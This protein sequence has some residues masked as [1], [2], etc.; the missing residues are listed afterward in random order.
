MTP[1]PAPMR[2]GIIGAGFMGRTYSEVI[3]KNLTDEAR[4]VAVSGGKRAPELARDYGADHV[5]LWEALCSRDDIDAIIVSSPHEHHAEQCIAAAKAGKHVMVEK[6]MAASVEGCDEILNTARE[7]GMH[8]GVAFTQR[9]RMNPMK[10]KEIIDSGELGRVLHIQGWHVVPEGTTS[11]PAWQNSRGNVGVL[12]GHGIHC[13]DAVRWLTGQEVAH[14]VALLGNFREGYVVEAS[15]DV[16]LEM[17][18]GVRAN[19][20]CS[21]EP[22]SPGFPQTQF[23]FRITC[24]EGLIALDAYGKLQVAPRGKAFETILVQPP[25]D[26][27]DKGF[28]DPIRL[29][30]YTAHL[31]EFITSINEGDFEGPSGYDG[32]QAVAAVFACYDSAK[33]GK[34]VRPSPRPITEA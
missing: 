8:V 12:L 3:T 31:D 5:A 29:E 27:K 23:G 7:S 26:W 9:K 28:L 1:S 13:F 2:F 15:S 17:D 6:P 32:R 25:I 19:I 22:P 14:A 21:F 24:E 16:L 10:A 4:L 20:M 33:S 11:L 30:S 18:N 34:R